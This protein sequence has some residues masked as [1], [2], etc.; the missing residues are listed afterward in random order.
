VAHDGDT[1]TAT[2]RPIRFFS[3]APSNP[4]ISFC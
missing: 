3:C 2:T 4:G 1:M